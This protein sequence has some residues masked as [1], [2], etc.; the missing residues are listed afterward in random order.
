MAGKEHVPGGLSAS[1]WSSIRSA[2]E[3]NRHAVVAAE[4]S[5]E[6]HH[7]ISG[8]IAQQA[9]LKASNPGASDIFGRCVAIS[10]D[11][12]VVGAQQEDS[13]ATGVNG[14]QAD[15]SAADSGAVYVF[16][17]TGGVWTQQAYLKASNAEANDFFG[18]SVAISGDTLVVG[19]N[20][21]DS[22]A[23]GVNGNQASNSAADSGAVYVFTRSGTTWT[24]Q[25]YLKAS[26]TGANDRF[27]TSVA[28]DGNTIVVGAHQ[29]DSNATGVNGTQANNTATDS[30][31]AYVFVR[32]GTTWS[33]QAYL[34]SSNSD[35]LDQ[36][37]VSVGISGETVV[38]GAYREDSNATGVNGSEANT[39]AFDAGAAY[40]FARSG[41][42]WSQQAYL[43]ASN[44][45]AGD[46]FGYAVAIHDDTV[47]IGAY[48]ED[49]SARGVNGNQASNSNSNAGAAYVFTRSM[50]TWTQQAYLKASNTGVSDLFGFSV[51]VSGDNL[52]I[53]AY[54]EDSNSTGVDGNGVDNSMPNSGA[55]YLFVRSGLV[56][57]Q[58]AY[59]KASNTEADD[60]F[61]QAVA[62]HGDT[63][64]VGAI[65]EDSS[66][67]G[68]NGNQADNGSSDAGA[69]YVFSISSPCPTDL[70]GSGEV[71]GGDIGLL[72]LDFGL[73]PGCPSDLD[74]S[75]EVDG[76]DIGL[77][78]LDFGACP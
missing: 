1:D 69:A 71:D 8:P 18:N 21:E 55:V 78:L 60:L 42:T 13:N 12:V 5:N 50:A 32:S 44:T 28:I 16:V 63:V 4:N 61:G 48:S 17:R 10:G 56:W 36:F 57:S 30:G 27:G 26:N 47:V 43:K 19:D 11:T 38:V 68:V 76:A 66:A 62:I 67:S 37:G 15:D 39:T 49:S 73:C 46:F 3:A 53:G 20:R 29:E 58:Q 72:L 22:D 33:Q 7:L 9:Y 34:K 59:L 75:G 45:E 24:Q 35:A 70:D 64:V 31:A 23:T 74:G 54:G 65:S 6:V 2:H 25:A 51:S 14:N 77:M 52:L 41:T 40:V